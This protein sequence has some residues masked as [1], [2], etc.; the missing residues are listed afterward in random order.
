VSSSI[1]FSLSSSTDSK[2][3]IQFPTSLYDYMEYT[4]LWIESTWVD[5][6]TRKGLDYMGPSI[7]SHDIPKFK[8]ILI[9]WKNLFS[10]AT[11]QFDVPIGYDFETSERYKETL[12]KSKTLYLI[13]SLIVLC[14]LAIELDDTITVYGL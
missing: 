9:S 11:E 3:V 8:E 1:D 6:I 2:K 14:D 10:L 12:D 4:F 5:D 13:E 7:I